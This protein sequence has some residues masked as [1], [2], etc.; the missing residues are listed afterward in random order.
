MRIE[1]SSRV[2]FAIEGREGAAAAVAEQYRAF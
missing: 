2:A 1:M